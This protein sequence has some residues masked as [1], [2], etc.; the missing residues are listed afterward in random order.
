M[1]PTEL[2]FPE[3]DAGTTAGTLDNSGKNPWLPIQ[4]VPDCPSPSLEKCLNPTSMDK[5]FSP[6]L[7]GAVKSHPG[8]LPDLPDRPEYHD[9]R[10]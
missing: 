9:F 4:I 1:K 6:G 8:D 3:L 10:G 7:M 5:G 2:S